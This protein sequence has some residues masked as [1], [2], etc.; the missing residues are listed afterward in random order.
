MMA[1]IREAETDQI[2]GELKQQIAYM[3][4]QVQSKFNT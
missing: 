3:D 2:V 4:I 1:R